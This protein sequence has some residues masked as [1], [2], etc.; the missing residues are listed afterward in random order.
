VARTD[1][2][3]Q[4]LVRTAT[5][6]TSVDP[7]PTAGEKYTVLLL[8]ELQ[9]DRFLRKTNAMGP[10]RQIA[11]TVAVWPTAVRRP[12]WIAAAAMLTLA[13]SAA[14]WLRASPGDARDTGDR[15][16]PA[17]TVEGPLLA[18]GASFNVTVASFSGDRD[19]K[20]LARRL[21]RTGAPAYDWRVDG[22]RRQVLL[23]PFVSIDEAEASQRALRAEGFRATRLYVDERL[24][25]LGPRRDAGRSVSVARTT[26]SND[27]AMVLVAAPGRLSLALEFHEE[28]R[29]VSG[30]RLNAS[31]YEVLI[32]QPSG[33]LSEALP[34][35]LWSAPADASLVRDVTLQ[36]M[37]RGNGQ[38]LRLRL[39]ISEAADATVRTSGHRVY[40]DLSRGSD[41]VLDDAAPDRG[42]QPE[43]SLDASLEARTTTDAGAQPTRSSR[44]AAVTPIA[45][46]SNA[47]PSSAVPT[48]DERGDID[49]IYARFTAI[50]PFLRSA[51]TT[52]DPAVLTALRGTLSELESALRTSPSARQAPGPHGLVTSAIQL[53]KEAVASDFTGDRVAQ[54]REASAQFAAARKSGQ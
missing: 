23:G 2:S 9:L 45:A 37:E 7:V 17:S 32:R 21:A 31:T 38:N 40:V 15:V 53:A 27:P 49:A 43:A 11:R 30:R 3:V 22:S 8:D 29:E 54:V 41:G 26:S 19:A 36:E 52:P 51:V 46:A 48:T 25:T 47:A 16:A 4:G 18:T 1:H 10:A 34:A 5:P 28:P 39:T 13:V 35:R 20:A 24:R 33:A 14:V 44:A 6:H 12:T 42:G 50:Q